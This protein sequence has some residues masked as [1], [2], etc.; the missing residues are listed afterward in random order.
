MKPSMQSHS[1][2]DPESKV[3]EGPPSHALERVCDTFVALDRDW[4]YTFVNTKAGQILGRGTSELIGK[5]FWTEFPEAVDQPFYHAYHRA[6]AEQVFVEIEEYYPPS[7]RWFEHRVYPTPDGVSIFFRDITDRKHVEALAQ[8][9]S[10]ILEMVARGKPVSVVLNALLR[11]VET[12]HPDLLSSILLLDDQ[13][14]HLRH[15]A[16]PSLPEVYSRAIDGVAIGPCV[17]SC[18][19]AAYRG[20]PVI[21]E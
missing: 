8:G 14:L 1:P 11:F 2:T 10:Q 7:D 9:Q 15:A 3:M 12:Q 13:G 19:T 20:E 17:G 5:H 4:R 16:S 21:V 18:G 6:L